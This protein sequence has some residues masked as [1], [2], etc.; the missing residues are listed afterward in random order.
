MAT[1]ESLAKQASKHE[2]TE[3]KCEAVVPKD[4]R[5]RLSCKPDGI[6]SF[7]QEEVQHEAK[8][9]HHQ[10][11]LGYRSRSGRGH[12]GPSPTVAG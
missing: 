6:A 7:S 4:H 1:I 11:L 9:F 3:L 10:N 5:I 2:Q 8:E 12:G